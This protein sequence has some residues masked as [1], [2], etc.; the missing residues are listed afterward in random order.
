ML[1]TNAL[2]SI[3]RSEIEEMRPSPVAMMPEG[4]LSTLHEDEINDLVAYL[5][6]RGDRENAMFRPAEK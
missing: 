3:R 2:T 4:L 1:D 6:S 5:L